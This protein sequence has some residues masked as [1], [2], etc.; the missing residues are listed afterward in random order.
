QAGQ[1]YD[2]YNFP[3]S[4]QSAYTRSDAHLIYEPP[5]R[6][7]SI[8]AFVRNIENALV[9]VDESESFAPPLSQPGTYNV[10]FQAPRTYGVSLKVSF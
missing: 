2:F 4:H 6:R 3:D 8:D 10:G 5:D 9:I 1:Y 7:W